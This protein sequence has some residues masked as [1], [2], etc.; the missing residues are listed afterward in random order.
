MKWSVESARTETGWLADKLDYSD[1]V[2]Q[3]YLNE[4]RQLLQ[5]AGSDTQLEQAKVA[6][7]LMLKEMEGY[8][9]A[10]VMTSN[11]LTATLPYLSIFD[12]CKNTTYCI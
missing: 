5:P 1:T 6:T 4:I 12:I 3:A 2:N 8:A 7:G 11:F 9:E 10:R